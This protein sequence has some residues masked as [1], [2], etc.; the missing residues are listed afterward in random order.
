MFTSPT[1]RKWQPTLTRLEDRDNP[2]GLP[3]L[4]FHHDGRQ[5]LEWFGRDEATS[6]LVQP[7]G[8][9]LVAGTQSTNASPDWAVAR[10]LPNGT[11]DSTFGTVGRVGVSFGGAEFCT[12]MALQGD[13]KV[14]LV[15]YTNNGIDNTNDFAVARLNANGTPDTTFDTDGK[16]TISFGFDDRA[17]GVVIQPDGKIVVA[18]STD[19]GSA[20]FAFARLNANG[21]LDTTF[22]TDGKVES[23]FGGA[24]FCTSVALQTDGKIVAGGFTNTSGTNDF[25]ALRLNTN[26]SLDTTFD[27]DGRKTVGFGGDARANAVLVQSDGMIVLAGRWIDESADSDFAVVRL[28]ADGTLNTH[29]SGDGRANFDFTAGGS[30]TATAVAQQADGKLVVGG[31]TDNNEAGGTYN[32]GVIRLMPNGFLDTSFNL[33]GK[34]QVN[35][36]GDDKA[37]G[38]ALQ[39][40]G[41]VLLAGSITPSSSVTHFAVARLVGRDTDLIART[42]GGQWWLNRTT[43][44]SFT[45]SA[46]TAWNEVAG[47]KDVQ[48]GDVNADGR[49]DILGRTSGGQWW[50]GVANAN[51]TFTNT[52]F[53]AWNELAGWKDVKA[54]D[55]NRDGRTDVA[56]RT[57]DGNWWV[58]LSTGTGF[59]TTHWGAWNEAAGWRDVRFADFTGDGR[60][61]VAGRTSDGNWW[62][63]AST[64]TSF[65]TSHFGAW[66]EAAGWKDVT[67]ADFNADGRA[68]IAGRTSGGNWW[69]STSNGTTFGTTTNFV[70]WNEAAGWRDVRVADFTGD[71]R[72]DIAGRDAGGNWWVSSGNGTTATSTGVWASWNEAAGWTDVRV[73]DF[74]GDGRV[75][76]AGRDAGGNW[77]VGTSTGTAF[78][79]TLWNTWNPTAGWKDVMAGTF[80]G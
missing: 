6:V 5:T 4:S 39:S 50:V 80:V 16:A 25:A 76:I 51:G 30:E 73:A 56:G 22:D 69:L 32:F 74:T 19:G 58:G 75:D 71:G 34:Q 21:T 18:G 10:F 72:A 27:T 37:Y 35:F 3:D 63:S 20:N 9:I 8:K 28:N 68:D 55:F 61:D 66:N 11:L 53:T 54:G 79:T 41:D 1:P 40:D 23:T 45:V 13:G 78:S 12:G 62:V 38:M 70:N 67:V 43:G 77:W 60:T 33:F 14:V 64:G 49:A 17:S 7:D 31:Y 44:S 65:A 59:V 42:S 46:A 15:G 24:D 47:W 29:F 26:G 36:G 2:A 52:L 48:T 57:S